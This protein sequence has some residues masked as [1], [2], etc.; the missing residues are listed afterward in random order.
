MYNVI[1]MGKGF[2]YFYVKTQETVGYNLNEAC[3]IAKR[4]RNYSPIIIDE[5]TLEEIPYVVWLE[6]VDKKFNQDK[7]NSEEGRSRILE[8]IKSLLGIVSIFTIL[9]VVWVIT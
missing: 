5:D 2:E 4:W 9:F 3:R 7:L 1:A 6:T 8:S